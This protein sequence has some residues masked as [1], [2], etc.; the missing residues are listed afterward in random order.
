MTM[1]TPN[2]L[3]LAPGK[4]G[5]T[6]LHRFLVGHPQAYVPAA[7]DLYYFDRY[8]DRPFSWYCGFF[9]DAPKQATVRMEICH[10]YVVSK[11]APERIRQ[12]LP[13]VKFLVVLRDPADRSWSA[14]QYRR[15]HG[16]VPAGFHAAVVEDPNIVSSSLYVDHLRHYLRLFDVEAFRLNCFEVL[17]DDTQA[18]ADGIA[19]DLGIE[20]MPISEDLNRRI[21]PESSARSEGAARLVKR[22][23]LL[24]RDFGLSSTVGRLKR[25]AI[26]SKTM[27]KVA[28][29]PAD[30]GERAQVRTELREYFAPSVVSLDETFGTDYAGRWGYNE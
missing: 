3:F 11:K 26:I 5:S 1:Q 9:A 15:K 7:K 25:S 27:Y 22:G 4:T 24:A 18:F 14:Y 10:D 30:V 29:D 6:W 23:A 19:S 12:A 21:L 28:P 16:L 8:Y 2:W 17:R 13:S 20:P